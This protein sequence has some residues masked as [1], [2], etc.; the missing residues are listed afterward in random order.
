MSLIQAALGGVAA[1]LTAESA[2]D[3]ELAEI[4]RVHLASKRRPRK[5][6]ASEQPSR[7]RRQF[8][9]LI[10]AASHNPS[11][12]DMAATA[13]AFGRSLRD[14]A[15]TS[16]SDRI[17]A[18]SIERAAD[19]HDAILAAL[20]ARDGAR[21]EAL[22]REHTLWVNDRYLEFAEQHGLA[23]ADAGEPATEV[24]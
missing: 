17:V 4:E 14:R 10:V 21:A 2:T 6:H 13:D 8:H 15:Q 7:L 16:G 18:E 1:R 12:I 5:R 22:M 3:D 20:Q 9:E 11:L 24:G 19:E 23:S